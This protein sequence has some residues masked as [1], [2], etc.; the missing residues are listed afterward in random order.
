MAK[1]GYTDRAAVEDYL[2]QTISESFLGRLDKWIEATEKFI[3]TFTGRN[4][5][6]D[7][8]ESERLF[9]GDGT[10]ELVIDDC[11]E[12]VKVEVGQDG[13][14]GSFEEVAA[15]GTGPDC[16]FSLPANATVKGKPMTMI[17]LNARTLL[18]GTQ[19]HRVTA[20]WGYSEE[21]P[22]DISLAATVLVAGIL[23]NALGVGGKVSQEKVGD[24]SVSYAN[25]Q[26]ENDFATVKKT[27]SNYRRIAV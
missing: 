20:K 7:S 11:I 10:N 21:V 14:G 17:R 5:I 12:I 19:N 22:A 2:L 4:F 26:Q 15:A 9:N 18:E 27:L 13:F 23:N 1:K 24:Y 6:A 16:Y 3:D 8:T 25:D